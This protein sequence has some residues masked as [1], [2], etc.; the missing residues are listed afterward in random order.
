M[1]ISQP[2]PTGVVALVVTPALLIR[3]SIL[4]E[5]EVIVRAAASMLD[6]SDRSRVR[7][8]I[9]SWVMLGW[10]RILERAAAM[11]EWVRLVRMRVKPRWARARAISKPIPSLGLLVGG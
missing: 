1:W 6:R 7:M 10:A 9:L 2:G 5:R 3:S 4:G 8:W 11:R